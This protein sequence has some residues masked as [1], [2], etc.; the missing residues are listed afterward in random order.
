MR[1]VVSYIACSE[2]GYIATPEGDLSFLDRAALAG[3]DYGY[4][5]FK[6]TVDTVFVGRKTY[7]KVTS[8]GFP[9]PHPECAL[10]VFSRQA[11]PKDW[12]NDGRR[13]W[14]S[15]N[16][17]A[18]IEEERQRP[19]KD[20]Y[21][22]GGAEL[23]HQILQAGLVDRWIVTTVPVRLGTGISLL[24]RPDRLK[25]FAL[26]KTDVFPNGVVQRTYV[27]KLSVA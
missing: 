1:L 24:D 6:A 9:D 13:T 10:V 5:A 4:A 27:K 8:L 15:T 12:P 7:D 11:P 17:V 22:D 26:D 3:E 14:S 2:D 23:L 21:C 25:D 19:G 18:W 16:P 20:L